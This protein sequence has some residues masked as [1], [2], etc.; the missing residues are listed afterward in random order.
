MV[1]RVYHLVAIVAAAALLGAGI[2]IGRTGLAQ[3]A[4]PEIVL[5]SPEETVTFTPE[6][7]QQ[8]LQADYEEFRVEASARQAEAGVRSAVP[9][10]EAYYADNGTY[11]GMNVELLRAIDFGLPETLVVARADASSYCVELTAEGATAHYEGPGGSVL[12]GP[13]A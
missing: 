7:L 10:I 5:S 3:D 6:E 11:A 9:A 12:D 1:V 2:F 8:R 13:C 4:S